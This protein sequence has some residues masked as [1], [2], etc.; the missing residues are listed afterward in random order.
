MNSEQALE[1]LRQ[2]AALAPV[3]LQAHA[4]GQEALKVLAEAIKPKPESD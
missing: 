2:L 4:Q 1:V 3:P